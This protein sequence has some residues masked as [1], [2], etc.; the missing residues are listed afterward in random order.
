MRI[1]ARNDGQPGYVVSSANWAA[2]R[3]GPVGIGVSA[4][5]A[6]RVADPVVLL[7]GFLEM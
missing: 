7:P 6:S 4:V 5:R 1:V 2:V 3:Y